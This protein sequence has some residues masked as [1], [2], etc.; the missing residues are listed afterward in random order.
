MRTYFRRIAGKTHDEVFLWSYCR[1]QMKL[2]KV[3]FL[4]LSVIL[5]TG[6]LCPGSSQ[7]ERG[8]CPGG[9]LC[10]EI[11]VQE[12]FCAGRFMRRRVSV[13]R[14]SVQWLCWGVSIRVTPR[15]VKSGWYASY[16]NAFL[17]CKNAILLK[18][19]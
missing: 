9:S 16:W 11:H 15:T 5:F 19:Y 18:L 7:S 3:M 1:P 6:G 12:G 4:H 14:V 8:L 13:Q 17:F 10:R 2:R